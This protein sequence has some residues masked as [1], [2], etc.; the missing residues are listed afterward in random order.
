MTTAA[1]VNIKG[2]LKTDDKTLKLM[3]KPT[4]SLMSYIIY[5]RDIL[6]YIFNC[7]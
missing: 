2:K 1:R 6:G 5:F 3:Q 4:Q 7:H